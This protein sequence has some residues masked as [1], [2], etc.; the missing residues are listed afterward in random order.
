MFA[1]AA[2][3]FTLLDY[4]FH[5]SKSK[6]MVNT[7]GVQQ[8]EPLKLLPLQQLLVCVVVVRTLGVGQPVLCHVVEGADPGTASLG[9]LQ[10]G[11]PSS[12]WD[13]CK[14]V[15]SPVNANCTVQKLL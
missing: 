4:F 7:A 8:V 6:M 5:A 12:P 2:R 1:R 13:S 14:L 3:A 10:L 11:S 15:F 9:V